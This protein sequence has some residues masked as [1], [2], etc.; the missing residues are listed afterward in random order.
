[1]LDIALIILIVAG[2]AVIAVVLFRKLP[3]LTSI[4]TRKIKSE[5]ETQRKLDLIERRLQRKL[6]GVHEKTIGR[7]HGLVNRGRGAARSFYARLQS[8]ERQYRQ[9]AHSE[10]SPSERAEAQRKVVLLIEE[11]ESLSKNEQYS[12]AEQRCI[13]AIAIEPKSIDAYRILGDVYLRMKE[14]AQARDVFRHALDLA[15]RTYQ[16]KGVQQP[17]GQPSQNIG[18]YSSEMAELR[19]DLCMA[20]RGLGEYDDAVD[21]CESALEL[22]PNNPKFLHGTL[23]L[24]IEAKKKLLAIRVFDKLKEVNP[25]NQRLSEFDEQ[26]KAL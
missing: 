3:S 13:E 25:E 17:N 16:V 26:V 23:E 22:M 1:M 9:R 19:Y 21:S 7:L 15:Q 20:Q 14:H 2:I 11:A 6:D 10:R 24:A 5:Q 8:I 4:D 12:E 18:G